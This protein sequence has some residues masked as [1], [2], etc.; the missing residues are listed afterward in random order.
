MGDT[1]PQLYETALTLNPLELAPQLGYPRYNLTTSLGIY[2]WLG[3][4]ALHFS[5]HLFFVVIRDHTHFFNHSLDYIIYGTGPN[6]SAA[7]SV[8]KSLGQL[9]SSHRSWVGWQV[10]NSPGGSVFGCCLA[11]VL[12]EGFQWVMADGMH[13]TRTMVA[14]GFAAGAKERTKAKQGE[15]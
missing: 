2:T 8:L 13:N 14:N 4:H 7:L 1:T 9:R 6:I 5:W 12:V 3:T 11:A 15:C 10:K